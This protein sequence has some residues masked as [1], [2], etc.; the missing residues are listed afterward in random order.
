MKR[1][2]AFLHTQ[3][4]ACAAY[5]RALDSIRFSDEQKVQLTN[6]L[7]ER[8]A[9][10]RHADAEAGSSNKADRGDLHAPRLGA[11]GIPRTLR[12]AAAVAAL[13]VALGGGGAV[14]YATGAVQRAS[15]M[16]WALFGGGGTTQQA[17]EHFAQNPA[18]SATDAGY[19]LSADAV[20]GDA[21]SCYIMLALRTTSGAAFQTDSYL[22]QASDALDASTAEGGS[23]ANATAAGTHSAQTAKA[24]SGA[25]EGADNRR[26]A[27]T[28]AGAHIAVDGH[29]V[30]DATML[31]YDVD[32]A[33][34]CVEFVLCLQV[35]A[36]APVST[37]SGATVELAF[38]QV[39][40]TRCGS[41]AMDDAS[42]DE[43]TGEHVLAT[44][45]WDLSFPL[46]YDGS[47][48]AL[49]TG[50]TITVGAGSRGHAATINELT[51]SPVGIALTYTVDD[52]PQTTYDLG[53]SETDAG[54]A[55][56]VNIE[57]RRLG[58]RSLVVTLNT[59]ERI[60]MVG[61]DQDG[62]YQ[63]GMPWSISKDAHGL[64]VVT[65]Q[66]LTGRI[67]DPAQIASIEVDGVVIHP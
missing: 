63:D 33:D 50:Q 51:A 24:T 41:N 29:E 56:A 10:S 42:N 4:D 32:P 2:N 43:A 6:M 3:N 62:F 13:V 60:T 48:A 67:I 23:P 52:A 65:Y 11:R 18:T 58:L 55:G 54:G 14:A 45:T 37:L 39:V 59:G 47:P 44:G 1:T 25:H 7:V 40:G 22:L 16:L 31:A 66:L 61:T 57:A 64:A 34:D 49:A 53:T 8:S 36:N 35:G 30:P 5:V 27:L 46:N 19:T 26:V 15:E 21:Q 28:L 12:R 9:Q 17:I 38:S 20:I